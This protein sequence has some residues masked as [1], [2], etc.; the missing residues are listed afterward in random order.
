MTCCGGGA[1]ACGSRFSGFPC[2]PPGPPRR[3]AEGNLIPY[4]KVQCSNEVCTQTLNVRNAIFLGADPVLYPDAV[5]E[6]VF[7]LYASG[8]IH[9]GLTIDNSPIGD[10]AGLHL[11]QGTHTQFETDVTLGIVSLGGP[12]ASLVF[13]K[14]D[15][16]EGAMP[17]SAGG[18]LNVIYDHSG[19]VSTGTTGFRYTNQLPAWY[20]ARG[21]GI[22]YEEKYSQALGVIPLGVL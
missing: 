12:G 5:T 20:T 15:A 4:R 21:P 7:L 19:G 14:G 18:K 1:A 3:D 22:Y 17:N 10:F 2:Q 13:A 9:G 16:S 11:T 6:G 8:A